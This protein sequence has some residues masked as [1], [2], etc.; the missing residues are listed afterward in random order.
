MVEEKKHIKDNITLLNWYFKYNVNITQDQEKEKLFSIL[1]LAI[2]EDPYIFIRIMLYIAN[3]RKTDKQEIQYKLLIHFIASMFP[4]L[5]MA[6]LD[7]FINLG[8][9]DDIL[10]FLQ[11]P[12]ITER[13]ITWIKHK[14]KLDNDY[15]ILL[16]GTMI[17]KNINRI[18]YYRPK[19]NK[20]SKWNIFLFKILDDPNFNGITI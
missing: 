1:T 2:T 3:T 16:N 5:T 6:N 10:Y 11:T 20:K 14:A 8:K 4:E 18:I 7:L 19:L 17:N 12:N 13:V 15:N 9:K